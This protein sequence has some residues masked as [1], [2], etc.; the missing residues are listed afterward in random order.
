MAYDISTNPAAL[1]NIA[2]SVL[3]YARCQEETLRIYL[4]QM[5]NQQQY[6]STEKFNQNLNMIANMK[7]TMENM[8]VEAEKFAAFLN[9]KA[10]MLEEHQ[11]AQ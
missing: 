8:R 9:E 1:R 3:A 7:T 10:R 4:Q 11:K 6:I 2:S 5:S